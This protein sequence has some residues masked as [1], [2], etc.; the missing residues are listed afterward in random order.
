MTPIILVVDDESVTRRLVAYTLK[1]LG[2]EV[3]GAADGFEALAV[4]K[5]QIFDLAIVDIGLPDMDGF[6]LIRNLKA[7]E[8]NANIPII[9]FTA[10]NDPQDES[11]AF[12]LGSVG[13]LYKPFSTQELREIVTRHLR[14]E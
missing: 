9:T 2:V 3:Y 8:Q 6:E 14:L 11:L 7:I 1:P 4:A 13:F 5:E 12:E 10:R